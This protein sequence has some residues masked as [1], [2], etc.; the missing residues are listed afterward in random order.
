MPARSVLL[1][2][3]CLDRVFGGPVSLVIGFISTQLRIGIVPRTHP[4][5]NF[6]IRSRPLRRNSLTGFRL[7]CSSDIV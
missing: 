7:E 2:L 6:T 1:Q 5:D 3:D 4:L